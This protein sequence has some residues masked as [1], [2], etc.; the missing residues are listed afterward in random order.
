MNRGLILSLALAAGLVGGVLSRY[1]TPT[2]VLAQ[3]AAPKEIAAQSFVLMDDKNNIVGVFKPSDPRSDR[4]VVLL[5]RSGREVWRA[6]VSP[7][8]LTWLN[9]K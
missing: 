9:T 3:S 1:I 5:D 6:G 2:P 7:K 8:N 4:T